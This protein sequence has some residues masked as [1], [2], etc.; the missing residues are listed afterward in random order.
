M[1]VK[2]KIVK[3]RGYKISNTKEN[4]KE[5]KKEAKTDE[6][7]VTSEEKQKA[8]VT[9]LTHLKKILHP[10][11]SNVEVYTNNQQI[12]NSNGLY[13]HKS[14]ISKNFNLTIFKYK[15]VFHCEGYE[16]EELPDEIM[17]A[18]LPERFFHRENENA[19]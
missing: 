9:L 17:E 15:E 16:Y 6:E 18:L 12:F 14:Y 5:H 1:T 8:L 4:F 10:I 3:G 2:L 13:A 19:W 11:F 7:T